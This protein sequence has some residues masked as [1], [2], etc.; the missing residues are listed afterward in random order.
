MSTEQH[1]RPDLSRLRPQKQVV[2]FGQFA[3]QPEVPDEPDVYAYVRKVRA[4]KWRW[5]ITAGQGGPT[6]YGPF[7]ALTERGA[8]SKAH[9]A[10]WRKP[11][12]VAES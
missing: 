8:W 9:A 4:F 11:E 3:L 6:I 2:R 12:K 1:F 7:Y 10:A 5:H